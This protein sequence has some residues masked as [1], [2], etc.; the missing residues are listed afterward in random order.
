MSLLIALLTL[1]LMFLL[2]PL[3]TLLLILLLISSLKPLLKPSLIPLA[4]E[5]LLGRADGSFPH[6]YGHSYR[7]NHLELGLSRADSSFQ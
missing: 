3:L 7:N 5:S 4:F 1:L 6:I 2:V